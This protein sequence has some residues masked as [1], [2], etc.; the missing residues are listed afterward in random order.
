MRAE[1]KR[2]FT[3]YALAVATIA[4]AVV[5]AA[6]SVNQVDQSR[7]EAFK[8]YETIIRW[9]QWDA[10]V[11][12]ISPEYIAENPISRLDMDRLRLFRVTSYT[13]RS[14]G[15]YDEGMTAQQVV[16]IRMFNK[17]RGI[18]KAILDQQEWRY[19]EESKRWLL[20]SGLPD[21]TQTSY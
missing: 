11:D 19:D 1:P 15:V 6:C 3:Q 10:A 16:E 7:G 21:P 5:I 14:T 8:Q 12:F 4:C 2:N 20:H 17:N 18:E 9:S 13:V